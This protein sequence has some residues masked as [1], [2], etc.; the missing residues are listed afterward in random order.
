MG[1]FM[2]PFFSTKITRHFSEIVIG[3]KWLDN[4]DE[5]ILYNYPEVIQQAMQYP[6]GICL[7]FKWFKVMWPSKM[8]ISLKNKT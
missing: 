3:K 1:A 6:L 8:C 2:M 4:L 5:L 7:T